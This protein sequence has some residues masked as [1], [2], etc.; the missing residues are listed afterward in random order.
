[1]FDVPDHVMLDDVLLGNRLLKYADMFISK[2]DG[3]VLRKKEIP[4]HENVLNIMRINV[5]DEHELDI[6][7]SVSHQIKHDVKELIKNYQP[8]AIKMTNI[9]MSIFLTDE[10]PIFHS[11]RRLPFKERDIVD[12]QVEQWIQNRIVE[13]CSSEFAS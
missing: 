1:M 9:E 12:Q 10:T 4:T 3:L 8:N 2:S 7:P 11:L 5:D 6:D 13:P